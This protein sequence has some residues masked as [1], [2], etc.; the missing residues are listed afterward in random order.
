M[1]L[2]IYTTAVE[3]EAC[4]QKKKNFFSNKPGKWDFNA[5]KSSL[6]L[7]QIYEVAWT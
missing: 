4:H 2:N 3:T 5:V 1:L 6:F 7:I